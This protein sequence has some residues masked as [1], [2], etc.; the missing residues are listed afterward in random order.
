[1]SSLTVVISLVGQGY[2]GA[3]CKTR[4]MVQRVLAVARSWVGREFHPGQQEQCANFVRQVFQEAG[5]ELAVAARPVDWESCGHLPQG[6]DYANSFFSDE[7]GLAIGWGELAPGDLVAFRDT[8]EGDFPAGCIT[9]VGIYAGAGQMIDRS[10]ADGPVRQIP[11]SD[12]WRER[13]VEA[14][15]PL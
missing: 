14:R 7:V 12:W 6:P 4:S 15:R 1:M 13:F 5:V 9:H 3:T 2:S 10:T 8:Y 11:L